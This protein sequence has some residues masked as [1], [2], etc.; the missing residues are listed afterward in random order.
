M[1]LIC[2]CLPITRSLLAT[3]ISKISYYNRNGW[4]C[5]ERSRSTDTESTRNLSP[6]A[7]NHQLK[8]FGS[9]PTSTLLSQDA[10]HK[11]YFFGSGN[12]HDGNGK[13]RSTHPHAETRDSMYSETYPL[14]DMYRQVE[15]PERETPLKVD[16]GL[17][18]SECGFDNK[19]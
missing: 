17:P 19:S 12:T 5:F 6:S 4:L 1:A 11:E 13:P 10:S 15:T 14:A 18:S 2:A 7:S 3:S 8:V 9:A 16:K